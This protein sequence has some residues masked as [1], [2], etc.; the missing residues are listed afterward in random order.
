MN[1]IRKLDS[2]RLSFNRFL[3][4]VVKLVAWLGLTRASRAYWTRHKRE[5]FWLKSGGEAYRKTDFDL[6]SPSST[7][8]DIGGFTGE[9][10]APIVCKYN[11]TCYVYEPIPDFYRLLKARFLKNDRVLTYEKGVGAEAGRR[12]IY[13]ADAGSSFFSTADTQGAQKLD[14]DVVGV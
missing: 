4:R 1:L 8:V 9:F 12:L 11:C 5:S 13:N 7:V 3:I 2:W 6:L 14:I 10:I